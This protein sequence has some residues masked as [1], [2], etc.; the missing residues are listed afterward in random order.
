[1][2]WK[3]LFKN[4]PSIEASKRI[5]MAYLLLTNPRMIEVIQQTGASFFHG[6]NANALPSIL[7]YGINSVDKSRKDNIELTTGE[8]WSRINGKRNFVSI[9]DCL[10][11]SLNYA[12]TN[13]NDINNLFNF[14]VV[15]GT[16]LKNMKDIRTEAIHSDMPEIG[17]I[18]N[19]SLDHI[20][21]LAVPK[22]KEEFVKKLIG[23]KDIE[24]V[25]MDID[26]IFYNL[27]FCNKSKKLDLTQEN[28]DSIRSNPPIF[29]ETQVKETV[30]KRRL[31][32]I[33][34]IFNKIK[35]NKQERMNQTNND[36]KFN[37][38]G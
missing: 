12:M 17:I 9:T 1:M 25:G 36:K 37:E 30:E 13:Q 8:E 33:K 32:K 7:K 15:I 27:D 10:N 31:S 6:T 4:N 29:T 23:Q 35:N 2:E 5:N 20:K 28:G 18:E 11:V 26:D 34:E 24:I 38:R 14:G 19:L 3:V 22:D 16:S 21:F